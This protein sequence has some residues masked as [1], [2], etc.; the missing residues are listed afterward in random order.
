MTLR[1]LT[2]L[3]LDF[4]FCKMGIMIVLTSKYYTENGMGK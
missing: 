3:S 2:N 4:F 1:H